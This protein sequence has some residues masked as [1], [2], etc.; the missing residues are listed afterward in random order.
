MSDARE[1]ILGRVRAAL[2][3]APAAGAPLT[4]TYRRSGSLSGEALVEL[5]CERAG[6]YRALVR[7]VGAS[8]VRS[9]TEQALRE[10]AARRICIPP[11]LPAEWRPA[12][13]ELIE[14]AALGSDELDAV[15]GVLTGATLAVAQTGTIILSG[16]PAEGRRVLTLIPDL[17]ICVVGEEQIVELLPQAIAAIAGSRTRPLTL[18]SGPSATSDI[19]LRRVEGVHGPRDLVVLVA[20]P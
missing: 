11:A 2:R 16:A 13:V 12:G 4:R 7:R 20:A 15:D 3:E 10:R 18:I 9:A 1:A 17:H 6:D 8:Q 5:F 19:E 14:D